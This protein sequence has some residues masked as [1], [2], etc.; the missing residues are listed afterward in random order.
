MSTGLA[1][2]HKL[3]SPGPDRRGLHSLDIF[4]LLDVIS[5]CR[6]FIIQQQTR[7]PLFFSP[8]PYV[9][10]TKGEKKTKYLSKKVGTL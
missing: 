9:V 4:I 2:V 8:H 1:P 3:S 6:S 7:K 5:L 10:G